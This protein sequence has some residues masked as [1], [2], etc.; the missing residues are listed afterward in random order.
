M[1]APKRPILW[2][3]GL[4]LQPQHF[5]QFDIHVQSLLAP[6]QRH[7]QPFFWGVRR[8]DIQQASL[9]NRLFE[10]ASVEAV[11]PD[12]SRAA[13]PGNAVIQARSFKDLDVD[14]DS[15]KPFR[16]YL[17]LRKMNPAGK[18]AVSVRGTEDLYSIPARFI[19]DVEPESV[20]DM[21]IGGPAA[22]ARYMQYVLKIFWESEVDQLGDYWLIPVA[23]LDLQGDR[24]QPAA[25]FIPPVADIAASDKLRQILKDIQ[26][27]VRS[28]SHILEMH[29]LH[30]NVRSSDTE[31]VS[32]RYLLAL[33]VVNRYVPLIHHL[34]ETL[35]FH[36]WTAYGLLRQLIGELSTFSDRIDALGRLADGTELLPAYDHCELGLCFAE[37]Q[38]LIKELLS[39]IV[40][41]EE[42]VIR[43]TREGSD[44]K[45]AI[46]ADVLGRATRFFLSVAC[47]GESEAVVDA[48]Q[49]LA[50]VGGLEEMPT[51]IARALPGIALEWRRTPPPG[52][53]DRPNLFYF[54]MRADHPLWADV[55]RTGNICLHWDN[56]PEDTVAELII[57]RA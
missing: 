41:G 8:L 10:I 52:L 56:A 40:V 53:P 17:G 38:R 37:A 47:P 45:G 42:N 26:E 29:K 34:M 35:A 6:F 1:M 13:F 2:H 48:L 5:Q 30:R 32:L 9:T 18:N 46:A 21:Y 36:P 55:R 31:P 44:F 50:K 24:V 28:R 43:L 23:Q 4:F 39:A 25:Q 22:K 19:S 11:F 33:T 16:V 20:E 3:Q 27:Y 14:P 57:A 49:H 12:G 51:L 15:A 54:D 7:V